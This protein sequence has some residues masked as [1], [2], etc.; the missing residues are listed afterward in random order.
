[1]TFQHRSS[2]YLFSAN[3]TFS[4]VTGSTAIGAIAANGMTAGD[5]F[6]ADND[7]GAMPFDRRQVFNVA[8]SANLPGLSNGNRLVKGAVNGW[9]V[10]G[11]MQLM[12][13]ANLQNAATSA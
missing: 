4:K 10:S 6:N 1:M 5:G 11:I 12:S 9:T 13:G 7:H 3:Y 8:Y 2:K